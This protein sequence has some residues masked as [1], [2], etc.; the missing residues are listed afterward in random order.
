MKQPILRPDRT[1]FHADHHAFRAYKYIKYLK[2]QIHIEYI[3]PS[4]SKA[5]VYAIAFMRISTKRPGARNIR[6]IAITRA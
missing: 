1:F 6:R 4:D 2:I 5:I 3:P